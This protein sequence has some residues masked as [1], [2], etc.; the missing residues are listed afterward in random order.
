MI[1]TNLQSIDR[2]INIHK[3]SNIKLS[4]LFKN[5]LAYNTQCLYKVIL[6]LLGSLLAI[7]KQCFTCI[8]MPVCLY[9]I[10]NVENLLNIS[11]ALITQEIKKNEKKVKN[12]RL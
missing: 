6:Q 4:H 2:K 7:L 12:C 3:I 9:N 10:Y 8:C 11:T 5:H 1:C